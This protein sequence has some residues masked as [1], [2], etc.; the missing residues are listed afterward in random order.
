MRPLPLIAA[1]LVAACAGSSE[2]TEIPMPEDTDESPPADTDPAPDTDLP[3]A[4]LPFALN[5]ADASLFP[6]SIAY[7]PRRQRFLSGSLVD[8]RVYA[9]GLDGAITPLY[10]PT[11]GLDD[12]WTTRGVKLDADDQIWACALLGREAHV[13]VIDAGTG[14]LLRDVSLAVLDPSASCNDIAFLPD[15][16]LITDERN[17]SLYAVDRATFAASVW[18]TDPMLEGGLVGANGIV[19][20]DPWVIVGRYSQKVAV[21][22]RADARVPHE[23]T[24]NGAVPPLG[25]GAGWDGLLW[26]GAHLWVAG[27]G[28]VLR[29]T[30]DDADWTSATGEGVPTTDDG[31]TS[32]TRAGDA[33]YALSSDPIAFVLHTDPDLPFSIVRVGP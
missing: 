17:P 21:A 24:L 4:E 20:A 30:P 10:T 31:W 2:I 14:E 33:V 28:E 26:D 27:V 11:P 23:V 15:R 8:G 22:M 9:I 18:L 13:W 32:L 29:F 3:P 12:T 7:D 1:L 6:E 25:G 16:A 5:V 19:W